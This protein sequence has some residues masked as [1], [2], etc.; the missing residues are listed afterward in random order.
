MNKKKY[1]A[2][3]EEEVLGNI[4]TITCEIYIRKLASDP[5]IKISTSDIKLLISEKYKIVSIL[6]ENR[7]CNCPRFGIDQK[8]VWKFKILKPRKPKK[9]ESAKKKDMTSALFSDR[10]K[11][12][13]LNKKKEYLEN[14]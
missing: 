13:A 12:I 3:I 5:V 6:K 10:I 14:D 9:T 4:L 2:A 7:I 11:N 1:I 8:G